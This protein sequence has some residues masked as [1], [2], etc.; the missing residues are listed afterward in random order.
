MQIWFDRAE[1]TLTK[2]DAHSNSISRVSGVSLNQN[3]AVAGAAQ[4]LTEWP[5]GQKSFSEV[6]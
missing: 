5:V 1:F 4:A 3:E 2:D 6:R